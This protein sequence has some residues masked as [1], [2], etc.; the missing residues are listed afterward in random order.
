MTKNNHLYLIFFDL[1]L[2]CLIKFYFAG[3]IF[4]FYFWVYGVIGLTNIMFFFK[5]FP[6]RKS[7]YEVVNIIAFY[8]TINKLEIEHK[9]V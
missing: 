6:L 2:N 3:R 8:S 9:L 5:L 4:V 7:L 1:K